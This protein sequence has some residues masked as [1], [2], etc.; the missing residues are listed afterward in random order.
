MLSRELLPLLQ[1]GKNLLAF[2]GGVDSTALF[3]LL[4]REEIPFDIA[5]VNYQTRD[6]SAEE[7]DYARMLAREYG[8]ECFVLE[9]RLSEENFEAEAR[10]VRYRFF[11]RVITEHGYANLITAHQLD[12]RLEWL[13]M[14]LTK[15][16]G[17]Y[18][19]LGMQGVEEREC[20]HLLRPLLETRKS[21]LKTFLHENAIRYF[22]DESN[23]DEGYRRNY[24]R[25]NISAPLLE[26]YGS[27]IKRSFAYL[28]E[29]ALELHHHPLEVMRIGELTCFRRPDSRR[30]ALIT[31]DR[32]LKE[33][34]FLMR[35]G[36]REAL[37]SQDEHVVGRRFSVSFSAEFC[38]IA[39]FIKADMP[40]RFKERCRRL[41][42]PAKLRPYLFENAPLFDTVESLIKDRSRER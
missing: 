5:I 28:N 34:G 40:K 21:V 29:D 3:F 36:D 4:E 9:T 25:H 23:R 32:V 26:R 17:L 20:Y 27:G 41:N 6:Q 16:A 42:I 24:F 31:V 7:I 35:Q 37:K 10:R 38:F 1:K 39:P 2:S 22:E 11:E 18:E 15:G 13:L 33:K 12:D 19:L 8:K 14:Q 30:R